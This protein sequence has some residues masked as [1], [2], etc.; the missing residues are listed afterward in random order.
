MSSER[1]YS[2]RWYRERFREIER[3]MMQSPDRFLPLQRG[4]M[5]YHLLAFGSN[6]L[7][8]TAKETIR[9]SDEELRACARYAVSHMPPLN[10]LK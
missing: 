1:K 10:D 3:Y 2:D 6:G 5:T 4:E 9:L 8:I 7:A